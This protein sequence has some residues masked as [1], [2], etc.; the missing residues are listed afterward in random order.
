M[1][2]SYSFLVISGGVIARIKGDYFS[3]GM[4]VSFLTGIFGVFALFF[5]RRSRAR[6]NDEHDIHE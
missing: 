2:L 4:G 3:R 6:I 1:G 5:S